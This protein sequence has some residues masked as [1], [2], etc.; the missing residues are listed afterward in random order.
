M[1]L[2]LILMLG[3]F[4]ALGALA[5]HYQ[6]ELTLAWINPDRSYEGYTPPPAPDYRED[7]A[8][9]RRG[10]PQDGGAQVFV[11]HSNVY[12]G[13]GN[14][15]APYDRETQADF[16]E[17]VILVAEATPF[18]PLGPVWAPKYRQPTIFARFTQKH[19][20]AASRATAYQD[21]SA[22]FTQFLQEA[23]PEAPV[24]VAGYG[25]GALFAGQL[26]LER[27]ADDPDVIRRT[28]AVY[29]IG[30]PLPARLFEGQVCEGEEQPRCIVAFTPVDARFE[31]YQDRLRTR[32]LTLGPGGSYV[33]TSG[34]GKLC[35]PPP[36]GKELSAID[37]RSRRLIDVTL[38]AECVDGLFVFQPPEPQA[39]RR[40]RLFGQQWFPDGVN[41][42]AEPIAEDA[43]RRVAGAYRI[44]AKE[45]NAV[46]PLVAPEEI[47]PSPINK[48][49][50]PN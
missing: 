9:F 25:D 13:D 49:P 28:A 36:M 29:A 3:I 10:G 16:I 15:N 4:A 7:E 2:V 33:S 37:A 41:L 24:I 8:W 11:I 42:F 20:G 1:R 39:L 47:V 5:W 30:M 18:E 17:D 34:V 12:R 45:E 14:W 46:P 23:D 22:A 6:D 26:F 48:V 21:I 31:G 38:D 44:M 43:A 50:E 27:I 40:R 32:T 35:A 19:P